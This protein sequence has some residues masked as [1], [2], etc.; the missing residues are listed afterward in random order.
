MKESN[1]NWAAYRNTQYI[2]EQEAFC[3]QQT[4][5]HGK[6]LGS[7]QD[8]LL[9]KHSTIVDKSWI[10]E[11]CFSTN[12]KTVFLAPSDVVMLGADKG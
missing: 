5:T 12:S 8:M 7:G 3:G 4:L 1:K 6:W 2:Q 11:T 9:S 10:M